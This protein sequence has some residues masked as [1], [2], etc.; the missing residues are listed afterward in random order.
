MMC[1]DR[2]QHVSKD[3]KRKGEK[4]A[5]GKAGE[6]ICPCRLRSSA[7]AVPG[8]PAGPDRRRSR[9]GKGRRWPSRLHGVR[10]RPR[11]LRPG[12]RAGLRHLRLV[13]IWDICF[14]STYIC[15]KRNSLYLF[16]R[17]KTAYT[18]LWICLLHFDFFRIRST[19]AEVRPSSHVVTHCHSVSYVFFER[20]ICSEE[21]SSPSISI[22]REVQGHK[23]LLKW[24]WP[25][26]NSK[27]QTH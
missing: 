25:T 15:G 26:N 6:P 13:D 1:L 7:L 21:G 18:C 3:N 17:W 12:H 8:Q 20:N 2:E 16:F 27:K 9:G 14:D 5:N 23:L 24:K 22:P 19:V 4:Q 10:H 11:P